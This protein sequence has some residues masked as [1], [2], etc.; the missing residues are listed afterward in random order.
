MATLIVSFVSLRPTAVIGGARSQSTAC[1]AVII[2]IIIIITT[3][4]KAPY[5]N[6]SQG[7]GAVK[8][9]IDGDNAGS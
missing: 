9:S 7:R 8:K 2:I 4:Y 1:G 5:Y 6:L 3:I